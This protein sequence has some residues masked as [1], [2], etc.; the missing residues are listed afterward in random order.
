[1]LISPGAIY[2][3]VVLPPRFFN[4]PHT[5]KRKTEKLEIAQKMQKLTLLI[6]LSFLVFQI[7][8]FSLFS[9]WVQ[10][11]FSFSDCGYTPR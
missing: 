10:T 1:M 3:R 11:P 2:N 7:F 4:Y 5:E 6:S 9:V 8:S